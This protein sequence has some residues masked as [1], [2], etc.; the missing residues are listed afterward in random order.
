MRSFQNRLRQFN[1]TQFFTSVNYSEK[2]AKRKKDI[3][4][5]IYRN[6][7]NIQLTP[8]VIPVKTGIYWIPASAGMTCSDRLH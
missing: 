5:N 1:F 8:V 3:F 7:L 2:K 6:I 4:K